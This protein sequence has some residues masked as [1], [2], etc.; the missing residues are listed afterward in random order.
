MKKIIYIMLLVSCCCSCFDDFLTQEPETQATNNNFWKNAQDVQSATDG[1]HAL[2]RDVFGGVT[3]RLYRERALPFD[4]LSPTWRDIAENNISKT[5]EMNAPQLSWYYEYQIIAQANLIIDNIHRADLTE[6]QRNTYLG[7]ALTVRAYTYFYI[8]RLWGDAPLVKES[9]D[10]GEK[11][12]EKWQ[13]LADFAISDLVRA[14]GILP[15]ADNLKDSKGGTVKTKQ[16]CSRGTANAI[17]AH[18][19]AWKA[20]LNNEPE[21]LAKGIEACNAVINSGDYELAE[22]VS[23]VCNTVLKGNSREG[24]FE[25][26]FYDLPDEINRSGSCMA[27]VCQKY[28]V[29]PLATPATRRT[30]LRLNF[31]TAKA[32]FYNS[33]RWNEY[34]FKPDSMATLPAGTTQGAVYIQKFRHVLTYADGSQIGRIRAY[35]QNEVIIRLADIILLRS[36]LRA[37]SGDVAG[38]VS[39]LNVIR[40]RAGAPLYDSTGDLMTAIQDE[41]DRELFLEGF[42][43]QYFDAVR[44]GLWRERLKD[45]FKSL[46]GQDVADGALFL[47]VNMDY[48]RYNPL[49]TQYPYWEKNGFKL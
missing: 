27:G 29:D 22:S 36:E 3:V 25:V 7:Q 15:P 35:D 42:S 13:V 1:L 23:E 2:F 44:T 30:L 46:T 45:G 48:F 26:Q 21:L 17:L 47:P 12:R 5:Y 14:A 16:Y 6:E 28:P 8:L 37:L 11:A 43:R 10:V 31:E 33:D 38:A 18:V 34:F 41:R 24:I 40:K 20:Q 39:D 49:A 32:M 4:Y 9:E 19:Y